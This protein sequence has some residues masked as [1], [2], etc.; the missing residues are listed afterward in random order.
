[1]R[2]ADAG[3]P[4]I[5]VRCARPWAASP[6]HVLE[7]ARLSPA[8]RLVLVYLL[9]LAA[10]PGWTIRVAQAQRALGLPQG[11]W[12][13]ARRELESVGYYSARRERD[14]AGRLRWVHEVTDE[15]TIGAF[16]T[17]GGSTGG[18]PTDIHTSKNLK[19]RGQKHARARGPVAPARAAA[20]PNLEQGRA[21]RRCGGLEGGVETW[22]AADR[23]A[24]AELLQHHGAVAVR[25]AAD[26]LRAGGARPLPTAVAAELRRRAGAEQ[27]RAVAAAAAQRLRHLEALGRIRA[28][29]ELGL[30][31]PE[32]A[33]AAAAKLGAPP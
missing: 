8:A 11:R 29:A 27:E 12:Q 3:T 22:T 1:M 23:Q 14:A 21:Q 32:A 20:N 25:D 4:E 7:D 6:V 9:G 33:A 31:T 18:K 10:R 30:I 13:R 16:S 5:R 17:D 26:A 2:P 28:D 19:A 24:V 15:P